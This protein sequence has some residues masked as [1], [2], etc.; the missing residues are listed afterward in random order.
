MRKT[1]D[2]GDKSEA[3]F[4]RLAE[5]VRRTGLPR[6][7]LYWLIDQ[8]DFPRQVLLGK[9]IVGWIEGE[10]DEWIAG[11]IARRDRRSDVAA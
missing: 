10:V 6:S 11:K 5:V 1:G 9:R 8:G 4:I 7:S 2:I 3:T